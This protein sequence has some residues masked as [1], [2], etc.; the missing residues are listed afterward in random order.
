[1]HHVLIL[2]G[3]TVRFSLTFLFLSHLSFC[4]CVRCERLG[5]YR[6]REIFLCFYFV[7]YR[8]SAIV[9][10]LLLY[11]SAKFIPRHLKLVV[12]LYRYLLQTLRHYGLLCFDD[13][14][15]RSHRTSRGHLIVFLSF[16]TWP[17]VLQTL[18]LH[19]VLRM[20]CYA[21]PFKH[22]DSLVAHYTPRMF[23]ICYH[24]AFL[25]LFISCFHFATTRRWFRSTCTSSCSVLRSGFVI[26]YVL[27]QNPS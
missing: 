26:A 27:R 6:Y 1:M 5:L 22:S 24:V 3:G 19:I 11:F 10:F 17:R 4:L 12:T 21:S 8:W 9:T 18:L 13:L 7:S 23:S 25:F 16:T 20:F 2:R 15:R 14:R